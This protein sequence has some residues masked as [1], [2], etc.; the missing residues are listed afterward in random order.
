MIGAAAQN[1]QEI[2]GAVESVLNGLVESWNRH[3]AVSYASYFTEDADFVNVLGMKS[4]GRP[5]IEDLHATVFRT[6]FRNSS[7]KLLDWSVRT[8]DGGVAL[9][10][11]R[12]EMRGHEIPPGAPFAEVRTGML[13]AVL[14]NPEG[15]WLITALQ[16]TDI[17][18]IS[19]PG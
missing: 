17:V 18:P 9:A 3:D 14:V 7:L 6:I 13:T 5:E 11:A 16:N 10:H 1:P 4:R 12:W 15:R 8:L 2:K 19:L